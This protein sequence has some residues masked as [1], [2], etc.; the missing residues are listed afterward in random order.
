MSG[1]ILETWM[2]T[3]ILKS[4]WH[5]GLQARFHFFRDRD[6]RE[7]DLLIERDNLIHPSSSRRLHPPG[8]PPHGAFRP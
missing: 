6:H 8:P 3:E 2:F 7:V 4:Y 5:N 1:A